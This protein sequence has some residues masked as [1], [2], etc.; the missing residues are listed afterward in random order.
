MP[1]QLMT[2]GPVQVREFVPDAASN[3]RYNERAE[4][5]SRVRV[6][7]KGPDVL[8][9]AYQRELRLGHLMIPREAELEVVR[10][11]FGEVVERRVDRTAFQ[12]ILQRFEDA[13]L[14]KDPQ[15]VIAA[16]RACFEVYDT[17]ARD[18]A[19]LAGLPEQGRGAA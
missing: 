6:L 8:V 15:R 4:I 11:L 3:E 17:L 7:E 14:S 10:R 13:V 12:T 16:W 19:T 9:E 1:T 5:I 18:L 2:R